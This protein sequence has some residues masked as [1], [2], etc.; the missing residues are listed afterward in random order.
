M[1]FFSQASIIFLERLFLGKTSRR[2]VKVICNP[3]MPSAELSWH[4]QICDLIGYSKTRRKITFT[5]FESWARKPRVENPQWNGLLVTQVGTLETERCKIPSAKCNITSNISCNIT[6]VS[7]HQDVIFWVS[8]NMVC[9]YS[10]H[11]FNP[12]MVAALDGH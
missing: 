2:N 1:F 8:H 10:Y 9:A 12:G 6:S 5:G 7:N 4:M 3:P 11:C